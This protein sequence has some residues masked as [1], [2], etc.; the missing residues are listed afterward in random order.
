MA[1]WL[2][3]IGRMRRE[4]S[5]QM[6][7]AL[8]ACFFCSPR[9]GQDLCGEQEGVE[10]SFH[11]VVEVMWQVG[12][13][14]DLESWILSSGR[15][16]DSPAWFKS[17]RSSVGPDLQLSVRRPSRYEVTWKRPGSGPAEMWFDEKPLAR[18]F[19]EVWACGCTS[20]RLL[21]SIGT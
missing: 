6:T 14:Q 15:W 20:R 4:P 1:C 21:F 10:S 11:G 16:V 2:T 9:Q 7:L 12:S 18:H 17:H 3:G 5:N 19:I 13:V 8:C